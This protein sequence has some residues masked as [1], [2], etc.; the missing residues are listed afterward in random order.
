M[1]VSPRVLDA[2]QRNGPDWYAKQ[3]VKPLLEAGS[4]DA[5]DRVQDHMA[6]FPEPLRAECR[7][8]VDSLAPPRSELRTE[9]R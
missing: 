6:G 4:G 2:V 8:A 9:D 7:A 5:W 1:T 3:V